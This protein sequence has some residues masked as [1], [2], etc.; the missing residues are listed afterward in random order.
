MPHTTNLEGAS[1]QSQSLDSRIEGWGRLLRPMRVGPVLGFLRFDSGEILKQRVFSIPEANEVDEPLFAVFGIKDSSGS[2][3]VVVEDY[4]SANNGNPIYDRL[5]FYVIKDLELLG[6]GPWTIVCLSV[7][8]GFT[9]ASRLGESETT[10]DARTIIDAA[11]IAANSKVGQETFTP[12]F[13]NAWYEAF[14]DTPEG[15]Q[16]IAHVSIE[17]ARASQGGPKAK[18][19]SFTFAMASCRYPSLVVDRKLVDEKLESIREIHNELAAMLFLGD[20]IY[21]D[22][23]VNIAT[24]RSENELWRE[25]YVNT[26]RSSGMRSVLSSLPCYFVADDHEFANDWAAHPDL[27]KNSSRNVGFTEREAE[28]NRGFKEAFNAFELFEWW[29]GPRQDFIQPIVKS[30]FNLNPSVVGV[31]SSAGEEV[32][33]LSKFYGN[34]GPHGR[35]AHLEIGGCPF[36]L[37]DTRTERTRGWEVDQIVSDDQLEDLFRWLAAHSNSPCPVFIACGSPMAPFPEYR[38]PLGVEQG[39]DDS[40][41]SYPTQFLAVLAVLAS[42]SSP[43]NIVLLSGDAHIGLDAELELSLK[44]SANPQGE[45]KKIIRCLVSSGLYR[46]LPAINGRPSDYSAVGISKEL[47][48][49]EGPFA[50]NSGKAVSLSPVPA[51]GFTNTSTT[52]LSLKQKTR[53]IV[54]RAHLLE[55][56]VNP[57]HPSVTANFK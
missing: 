14:R 33:N 49:F 57:T 55:V 26:F 44:D 3:S 30:R 47:G 27:A 28:R 9:R 7:S 18:N 37:M 45:K 31:R 29:H 52:T 41:A 6:T 19:Q 5:R 48:S 23:A 53:Q 32:L 15:R 20:T 35:W 11:L 38:P 42:P 10:R 16:S 34:W 36:F 56:H 25:A 12:N 51:A 4:S 46:P 39:F 13:F 54:D 24:Q 2:W 1:T 50:L 40:W 43:A 21:A 17:A 22:A 8:Q